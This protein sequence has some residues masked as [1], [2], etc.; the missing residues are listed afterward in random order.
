MEALLKAKNATILSLQRE[1]SSLK[2]QLEETSESSKKLSG[3]SLFLVPPTQ[4]ERITAT[5]THRQQLLDQLSDLSKRAKDY[6]SQIKSLESKNKELDKLNRKLKSQLDV[7]EGKYGKITK[8]LSGHLD[9]TQSSSSQ[10]EYFRTMKMKVLGILKDVFQPNVTIT[11]LSMRFMELEDGFI[12][13][14]VRMLD[15]IGTITNLDLEG[16][17]LTDK[18]AYILADFVGKSR[19]KIT[20]INL[21][22]N[23][24]GIDG[25]WKFGEAIRE[26]DQEIAKSLSSQGSSS[27]KIEEIRLSFNRIKS[28]AALYAKI[29]DMMKKGKEHPRGFGLRNAS[30]SRPGRVTSTPSTLSQSSADL[31]EVKVLT[32]V[33]DRIVIENSEMTAGEEE[34]KSK[35]QRWTVVA[36]YQSEVMK[37][38]EHDIDS[39]LKKTTFFSDPIEKDNLVSTIFANEDKIVRNKLLLGRN[40]DAKKEENKEKHIEEDF[41]LKQLF[42]QRPGFPLTYIEERLSTGLDVNSVDFTCDET[43]L[44]YGCRTG[45]LKLVQLVLRKHANLDWKNVRK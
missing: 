41:S 5:N 44:M 15:R 9:D 16:N 20:H 11:V 10:I 27:G 21:S 25:A 31:E 37:E 3:N 33:L 36:Q 22:F 23:G 7:I 17:L 45:N 6:V 1:V 30:P 35:E 2:T 39:M 34:Q 13:T 8:E 24:I 19:S 38:F 32:S 42:A 28:S 12:P 18:S 43:L 26:K 14:V 29:W 40:E 4:K